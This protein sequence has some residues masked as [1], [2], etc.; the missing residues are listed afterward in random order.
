MKNTDLAGTQIAFLGTGLMGLPMCRRLLEAGYAVRIWNRT[1]GKAQHLVELGGEIC[2]APAEAVSNAQVVIVMLSDGPVVDE[3][4]FG[5]APEAVSVA[6][7]LAAGATVI[8]MS[9]IPVD[10]ARRQ[11]ER[12][13]KLG[14]KYIDAPVSGG[15]QGAMG[16]K[17][18]IMAGGQAADLENMRQVME[19]MGNVT[20]VG[21]V[22]AG[23][24]AKLA[25]QAIV[26]ITIGAVAEALLLAQR[27]GADPEAVRTALLGGFADST[28]LRQ[29][30]ER[31]IKQAF[32]PGGKATTQLKD[33]RTITA[34]ARELKLD[35]PVSELVEKLYEDMCGHDLGDLDHSALYLE[36]A[37]RRPPNKS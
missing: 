32:E 15:E 35:L 12:L 17:L 16:G 27:G 4:L 31:M 7:R 19:R 29:H 23:Q 13:E 20:H 9:S 6:D 28:I 25:N 34:L 24:L 18:T 10:T 3:V 8:V 30:G 1:A 5:N 36:I 33:M 21:P 2:N 26:G 37:S 22:G 11:S 14:V